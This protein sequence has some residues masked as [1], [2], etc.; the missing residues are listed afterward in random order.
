[1]R[2]IAV[3]TLAALLALP[4]MAEAKRPLRDV[5]Q[6]DNGLF[7]IAVADEIRKK[8]GEISGRVVKAVLDMQR[9]RRLAHDL[10]YSDAEIE[11]YVESETERDRMR[12]RGEAYLAANGASREDHQSLCRLGRAEIE[13]NSAIGVYLRAK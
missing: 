12:R 6:I 9:L 3:L 2:R 7:Y 5:P 4:G 1:M 13:R 11:A 8:C 10:G